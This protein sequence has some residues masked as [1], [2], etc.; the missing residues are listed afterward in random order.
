MLPTLIADL[1]L[2]NIEGVG[3]YVPTGNEE[4]AAMQIT[5]LLSNIVGF[6]TII[7]GLCFLIYFAIGALSWIT[8]GGKT[9]QVEKAKNS[10]TNA[11]IGMVATVAAYAIASIVGQVLGFGIL[12]LAES[13]QVIFNTLP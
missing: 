1:D 6:L 5:F 8:A 13:L 10:M 2:G 9:D 7:G 12:D 11:A 3:G 4:S